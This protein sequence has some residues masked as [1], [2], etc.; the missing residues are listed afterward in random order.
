MLHRRSR[1]RA[2]RLL[3]ST[4]VAGIVFPTH[5]V[6]QGRAAAPSTVTAVNES[7]DPLLRQFTFRPIGPAVMMGRV[8]DITGPDNDAMIMYAGF[9]TGG[10]WKTQDGG[11]HWRPVFDQQP[12][13]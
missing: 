10:V 4:A 13:Q 1:H 6:A 9:A 12:N 3:L 2:L 7:A 5:L 11:A 8:D